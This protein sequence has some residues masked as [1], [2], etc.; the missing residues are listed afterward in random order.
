MSLL[1]LFFPV[2]IHS[3]HCNHCLLKLYKK[4]CFSFRW[5]EL[6]GVVV[7][8]VVVLMTSHPTPPGLPLPVPLLSTNF[9]GHFH[10]KP[11]HAKIKS[12]TPFYVIKDGKYCR[13]TAAITIWNKLGNNKQEV[14]I[15]CYID[16]KI[17]NSFWYI[18][19]EFFQTKNLT[20]QKGS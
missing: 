4:V 12:A 16:C 2:S 13:H 17:K 10:R 11:G 1:E 9:S 8:V 19:L 7:V 5:V 15:L 20:R 6:V 18:R 14:L 3:L